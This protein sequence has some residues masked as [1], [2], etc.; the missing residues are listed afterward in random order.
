MPGP[1]LLL[2]LA[3]TLAPAGTDG[4]QR[5]AAPL[6]RAG[7]LLFLREGLRAPQGDRSA[8][9][10]SQILPPNWLSKRQHPGKREEEAEEGLEEEEEEEWGAGGPHKRQHPGRREDDAWW[11]ADGTQHKRQHPGRR[12]PWPGYAVTKR[13]HPGRRLVEP[14][15]QR[16]WDEEE[17]EGEGEGEEDLTAEKRQHPGRR[18]PGGPCGPQGACGRASVLRGLLGDPSRGQGAEE[19]RQHPGRRAAWVREPLQA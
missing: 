10:E 1:W 18:S 2:A 7:P 9:S 12:A 11:A 16:N 8:R 4:A 6:R 15:A 14:Q 17:E 19:Q 13:Q 5:E 3:V